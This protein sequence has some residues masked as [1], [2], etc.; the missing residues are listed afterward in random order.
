M[1][2][3]QWTDYTLRV[4]MYCA[5]CQN[6]EQPVTISE[7]AEGYGI[8]RSHLTKIVNELAALRLLETTRGRGGGMRLARPANEIR[9]G[10]VVRHTETDFTLVE[11]FDPSLDSCRL[12]PQ[13]ALKGALGRAMASFFAEL[14]GVT[15]ADL[16]APAPTH[17]TAPLTRQP[18]WPTGLPRRGG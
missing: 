7:I 5:A 14:D 6:R 3:T 18:R 11:C 1:R 2:L 13:C 15:L 16:V 17:A 9:L 12:S 8:S 10:E 4:L